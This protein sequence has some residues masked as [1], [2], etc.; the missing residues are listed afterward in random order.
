MFNLHPE[1]LQCPVVVIECTFLF[2]DHLNQAI[3]SDHT[4][5]SQIE[6]LIKTNENTTFVLIHFSLRYKD[7]EI[8]TFFNSLP[9]GKPKNVIPWI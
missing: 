7:A 5:Y 9:D 2:P 8:E 4:H 3:Q 1:I 6:K